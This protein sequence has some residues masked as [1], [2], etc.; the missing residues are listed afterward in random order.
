VYD[1]GQEHLKMADIKSDLAAAKA[2]I[3]AKRYTEARSI[4]N[5][6][7]HPTSREWLAK[8]DRI[9]P[10]QSSPEQLAARMKSYTPHA[11]ATI[12]LYLIFWLP[13]LIANVIFHNEGKRME[14]IAGQPLPGVGALGLMRKW[15]FIILVVVLIGALIFLAA[16]VFS[17]R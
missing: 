13:G 10:A 7:D 6:V 9:S 16:T 11:V 3:Q 5:S 15:Q 17:L 4:L 8:L 2:L 14:T 12:V 1:T